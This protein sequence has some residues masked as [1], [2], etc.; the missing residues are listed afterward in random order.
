MTNQIPINLICEDELSLAVMERLLSETQRPF[1]IGA[2][3]WGTG[4]GYIKTHTRAFNSA[5]KGMPYFIL[6]DLDRGECAPCLINAWLGSVPK[7]PNLIFRVSVRAVEAWL[8]ADSEGFATFLGM[9]ANRIPQNPDSIP[10][11]KQELIHTVGQ[12]SKR[13]LKKDIVPKPG[14]GAK[15]GPAYNA[16][17]VEFVRD[18]W[19]VKAARHNSHSLDRAWQTL[20]SFLPIWP[21]Q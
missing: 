14:S 21:Q 5:A 10:D 2:S 4:F 7:H 13:D 9:A 8:L 20:F 18:K 12:S 11:P 17:L 19:N 3:Y 6:T 16:P 1:V 15:Q